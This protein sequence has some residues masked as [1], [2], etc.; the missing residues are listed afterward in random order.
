MLSQKF[1]V[2]EKKLAGRRAYLV[3]KE[4]H[5]FYNEEN[6]KKIKLTLW[7]KKSPNIVL[8]DTK[9]CGIA[10]FGSIDLVI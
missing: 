6:V 10:A 3:I 7:A 5:G 9:R 4:N 1:K 2:Y 8:E